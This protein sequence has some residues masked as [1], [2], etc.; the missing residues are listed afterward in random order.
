MYF[1]Q[2]KFDKSLHDEWYFV[3]MQDKFTVSVP[4][5]GMG[6]LFPGFDIAVRSMCVGEESEFV[7]RHE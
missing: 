4:R 3:F 2:F 5:I 6:E 7:I 1:F